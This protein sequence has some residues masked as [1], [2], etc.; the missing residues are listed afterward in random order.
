MQPQ[1]GPERR[2]DLTR[3]LDNLG[4]TL[5]A[6]AGGDPRTAGPVGGVAIY[7]P[8]D[9]PVLPPGALVLGVGVTGADRVADLLRRVAAQ[10]AA[11]LVVRAP[12]EVDG[13]VRQAVAETGV[14][15]LGLAPGASWAQIHALLRSLTAEAEPAGLDAFA[16][17]DLFA[18][19]NAICALIDAPVTIEDTESRVLAFSARQDEADHIRIETILGRKVPE[20]YAQ[21]DAERGAFQR[22]YRTDGPVFLHAIES[23]HPDG[24]LPRVA[25]AVRAGQELLGSI[26]AAVR[27]PLTADQAQALS[28]S[29]KLVALHLLK[30]RAGTGVGQRLMAELVAA[31]LQ[32]GPEATRAAARLGL[33]GTPA[34]VAAMGLA[35]P[36]DAGAPLDPVLSARRA[37]DL[38]H[39][40]DALALHLS[41]VRPGAAV[42]L[43][44]GV[45]YAVLPVGPRAARPSSGSG[46]DGDHDE[47]EERAVRLCQEF[48]DRTGARV[49]TLIG[50]GRVVSTA[51]ELR[52]SRDDAERALRVLR[53]TGGRKVVRAADVEVDGLLLDLRDLA[54]A[55]GRGPVGPLARLAAYDAA[56]GTALL[57]SLRAWLDAHGDVIVASTAVH[58]HENTFRYRLRRIA[59]IGQLDLAD[60]EVRFAT[61]VQLRVFELS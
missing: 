60:P 58:V 10:G 8:V 32:G 50:V 53:T 29:A 1:T 15:L 40:S 37:T 55:R 41:A 38:Q 2:L 20:P 11:A 4:A 5:L 59:E 28:D 17:D 49:P 56:K 27:G 35:E 31:V 52:R 14:V 30:L 12:V 6:A 51:V 7:D 54:E 44:E 42:A 45:V 22:L 25:I 39:A 21:K 19:A 57:P 61:A 26:W 36:A 48:L 24:T 23:G 34:V 47:A 13:G 16:G 33:E 9:E 43:L 46:G 18:V 3:I